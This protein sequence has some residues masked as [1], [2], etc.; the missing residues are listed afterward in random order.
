MKKIA[1][2]V[3]VAVLALMATPV[4]A[5]SASDPEP[6]GLFLLG[7]ASSSGEF[8][9]Q[10]FSNSEEI[11]AIFSGYLPTNMQIKFIYTLAEDKGAEVDYA[12]V[13]SIGS[14]DTVYNVLAQAKPGQ[15][16][17]SA[18]SDNLVLATA[19][20]SHNGNSGQ[21]TLANLSGSTIEFKSTVFATYLDG[22]AKLIVRAIVTQ[23]PLPAALP[24]FGMG[25][26]SLAAYRAR[27]R[28]A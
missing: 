22:T 26:A 28:K 21:T 19:H 12:K 17:H 5:V 9:K 18:S 11:D 13:R 1:S 10:T 23:V 20:M 25:I 3:A 27:K 7:T 4:H 14:T 24:L 15:N 2:F 6:Q 16:T 8:Y